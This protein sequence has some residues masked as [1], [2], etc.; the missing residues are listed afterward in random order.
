MRKLKTLVGGKD[1]NNNTD[2]GIATPSFFRQISAS[3]LNE[4]VCI[5]S[6]S[7]SDDLDVLLDKTLNL[8]IKLRH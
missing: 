7:E 4:S 6:T 1:E 2:A 8:L 5:T 3:S